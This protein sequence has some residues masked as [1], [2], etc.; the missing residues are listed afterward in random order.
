MNQYLFKFKEQYPHA[1]VISIKNELK[2]QG[3]EKVRVRVKELIGIIK[4][5]IQLVKLFKEFFKCLQKIFTDYDYFTPD[6]FLTKQNDNS[7]VLSH[8]GNYYI[9][10]HNKIKLLF[11]Y[12][13]IFH[14]ICDVFEKRKQSLDQLFLSH[15]EKF[16][17]YFL[18][19]CQNIRF[20]IPQLQ[21]AQH[22]HFIQFFL[23][24]SIYNK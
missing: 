6:Q 11:N 17:D 16:N 14:D 7:L 10:Y 24:K 23:L 20:L 18:K 4:M 9:L 12:F 8:S 5:Q 3:R 1:N 13:K 22:F 15:E 2:E 19:I 21:K